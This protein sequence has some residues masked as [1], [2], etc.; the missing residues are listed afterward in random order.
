MTVDWTH[1]LQLSPDEQA[2][3]WRRYREI[4]RSESEQAKATN[5]R[6]MEAAMRKVGSA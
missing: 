6:A 5:Y 2:A 4:V 1:W 3:L